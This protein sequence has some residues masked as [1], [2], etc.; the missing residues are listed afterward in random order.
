MIQKLRSHLALLAALAVFGF[1]SG[2]I[3]TAR[4]D[5]ISGTLYFTTFNAQSLNSVGYSYNGTNSFSISAPHRITFLPG[6]DG[7]VFTTN[8][9]IAVGGQGNAVYVVNPT[10]GNHTTVTA[11]STSA[12]HMMADPFGHILSSGIPGT[13]AVYNGTVSSNGT[14]LNYTPSVGP[15]NQF[16]DT[17][18]Y[19]G[20]QAFY[21][22]SGGGGVGDFGKINIDYTNHTY[23]TQQL[24]SGMAGFHGMTYDPFTGDLF[25]F[26]ANTIRQIDPG[27]GSIVSTLN[28]SFSAGFDQGTVDGLGHLFIADNDGHLLFIDYSQTGL[29]STFSYGTAPFLADSLDD[30]APIAGP[31]G[32]PTGTPEP[33][34]ITLLS[35]GLAGLGG[36]GWRNRRKSLKTSA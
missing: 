5:P 6:A 14:A 4:G 35:L 8:G 2:A 16:V 12:F 21:T 24:Y 22:S 17:I 27:T 36:Y 15:A 29:V 28:L 19:A 32:S 25:T 11:G 13:P 33:A 7:L 9:N 26:G 30:V 10:N 3:G 23:T 1:S 18:T 31:G 20:N 34:S